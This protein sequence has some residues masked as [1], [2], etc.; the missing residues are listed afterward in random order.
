MLIATCSLIEGE[1]RQVCNFSSKRLAE[2]S[3]RVSGRQQHF[4]QGR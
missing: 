3:H 4:A 1:Q 2:H